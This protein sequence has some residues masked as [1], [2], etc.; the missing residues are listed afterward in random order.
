M[1]GARGG[2][3]GGGGGAPSS[4][5]CPWVTGAAGHSDGWTQASAQDPGGQELADPGGT[6]P[7]QTEPPLLWPVFT[8]RRPHQTP[9]LLC[10]PGESCG[11][12]FSHFSPVSRCPKCQI[13]LCLFLQVTQGPSPAPRLQ[14]L[15][16]APG[17]LKAAGADGAKG[18][19]L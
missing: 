8:F 18:S 17:G 12:C 9:V 13:L 5:H 1:A 14:H 6:G 3:R 2:G 15:S 10:F 7:A 19:M 4:P 16:D 11:G